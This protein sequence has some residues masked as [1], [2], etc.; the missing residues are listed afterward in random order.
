[1]KLG[2]MGL[3]YA[4]NKKV[5][6]RGEE[7]GAG[8]VEWVETEGQAG[9]CWY[10]RDQIRNEYIRGTSLVEWFWR[11]SLQGFVLEMSRGGIV[12]IFWIKDAEDGRKKT[13]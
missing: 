4:K 8:R 7:G 11:Q 13:G 10:M 6:K 12:D 2:E 3:V 5:H 9:S 1:M